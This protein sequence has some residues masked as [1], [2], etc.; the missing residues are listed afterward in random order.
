MSRRV[1]PAAREL[2]TAAL[3]FFLPCHKQG[4][5]SFAQARD[6]LTKAVDIERGGIVHWPA[7]VADLLVRAQLS[8]D[9]QPGGITRDSINAAIDAKWDAPHYAWQARRDIGDADAF[10]AAA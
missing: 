5:L 6:R 8:L 2:W 1:D 9:G 3:L 7:E 4:R 10:E